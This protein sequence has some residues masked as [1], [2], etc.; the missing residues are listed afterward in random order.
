MRPRRAGDPP[1]WAQA[2]LRRALP[3]DVQES[4]LDDLDEVF[5]RRLGEAGRSRARLWYARE[6]LAFAARFATESRGRGPLRMPSA[7]LDVKLGVRMLARYPMLTVVS[8][9]ALA[10]A[11]GVA[12]GFSALVHQFMNPSLDTPESHRLVTILNVDAQTAD[13]EYR[14]LHDFVEWRAGLDHFEALAAFRSTGRNLGGE[15]RG[16]APL[17]SAEI[18]AAAFEIGGEDALLGRTLVEA[19]ERADAPRVAVIGFSVWTSRFGSDPE[20][21]G[22]VVRL[23]EGPVTIVGVMPEGYRFPWAFDMW[24]PFR[25]SPT[26]FERREGPAIRVVGWLRDGVTLDA[27]QPELEAM[28]TRAAL[29]YPQSHTHLRPQVVPYLRQFTNAEDVWSAVGIQIV[30][31]LML[32]IV[33]ANVGLLILART[34]TRTGELALRNALGASRLRIIGQLFAETLVLSTVATLVGLGI[35]GFAIAVFVRQAPDTLPFWMNFGLDA[36]DFAF[37]AG[38]VL[39]SAFVAGFVPGIRATRGALTRHLSGTSTGVVGSGFGIGTRALVS[40]QIFFSV[41]LL[42]GGVAIA[43]DISKFRPERL[44][45]SIRDYLVAQIRLEP[46]GDLAAE[47]S[48]AGLER[49]QREFDRRL[50]AEPGVSDVTFASRAPFSDHSA[51]FVEVAGGPNERADGEVVVVRATEVAPNFFDVFDAALLDGRGFFADEAEAARPSAGT[52]ATRDGSPIIVTESFARRVLTGREPLGQ[53]V[54][55]VA[56]NGVPF[57]DRWYTVVGVVTDMWSIPE[58]LGER[59]PVVYHPFRPAEA[60]AVQ[61]VVR[62]T[63]APVELRQRFREIAADV[64]PTLDVVG[65]RTIEDAYDESMSEINWIFGMVVAGFVAVLALSLAGIYAT[66]SYTVTR[67]TREI[68]I[69]SALGGRASDIVRVL[70][71]RVMTDVTVG[72][73]LATLLLSVISVEGLQF[74]W[75]PAV[76][77]TVV[78]TALLTCLA[79]ARRALRIRPADALRAEG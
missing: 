32:V 75:L 23:D 71:T 19:D 42:A 46:D 29:A 55:Y 47:G 8:G 2:L 21:V 78:A 24:E 66:V 3:D 70:A 49:I 44:D 27:V 54:R 39:L 41:C 5:Q 50:R 68:G 1:R 56:R 7:S 18:H 38:L 64:E 15:F 76:V 33:C 28:G 62:A 73:L 48:T 17:R 4:I 26:A 30:L 16:G 45:L 43:W 22:R 12:V 51:R 34:L 61:V 36:G 74:R 69:R 9:M 31:V 65:V 59:D 53:R 20:I 10:I 57:D 37:A 72:A 58:P 14:S 11:T 79:P 63:G 77:V 25:Y 52:D 13:A 60:S 6:A 40:S 67:R 35:A